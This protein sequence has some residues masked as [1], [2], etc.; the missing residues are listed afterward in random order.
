M[1]FSQVVA[2]CDDFLENGGDVLEVIRNLVNK[3][4]MWD[5]SRDR[6][7]RIIEYVVFWIAN[8]V[9]NMML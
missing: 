7:E 2:T 8:W 5:C 9:K 6:E 3:Y 1:A 4:N